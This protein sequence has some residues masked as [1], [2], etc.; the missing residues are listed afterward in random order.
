[1]MPASRVPAESRSIDPAR[2]WTGPDVAPTLRAKPTG[3]NRGRPRP[4]LLALAPDPLVEGLQ[5]GLHPLETLEDPA[6]LLLDGLHA[7]QQRRGVQRFRRRSEI[8]AAR[9]TGRPSH[10]P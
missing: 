6:D 8:P 4:L 5:L 2:V 10:C 7:I 9:T 3:S 1:M